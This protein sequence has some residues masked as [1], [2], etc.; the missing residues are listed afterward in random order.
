MY[1]V[2]V[3]AST[4]TFNFTIQ[5]SGGQ[6]PGGPAPWVTATFDDTTASSGYDVR[7]TLT[8]VGL[9]GDEFITETDFNINPV[10][11]PLNVTALEIS[12]PNGALVG[13]DF[14]NDAF[15]ADGDGFYDMF[16]DFS[17]SPPRATDG[18]TYVIDLNWTGG[19][20]T[21]GDF[22]FLSHP[23]GGSGPFPA[24]SHLQGIGTN[25]SGSTWIAPGPTPCPDC[26]P[27]PVGDNPV[28]E[29]GSM[30]LLGTGLVMGARSL[31]RRMG[32]T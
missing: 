26:V 22:D 31:R 8:T 21:A 2:V 14:G 12:D 23:G 1:P 10:I 19:T 16:L 4:L 27:N 29:P 24:A 32:R 6:S 17:S 11:N 18:F 9:T 15:K 7:L 30:F 20:L 13:V 5:F 25:G 28:P 3:G